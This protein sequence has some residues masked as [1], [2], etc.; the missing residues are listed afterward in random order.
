MLVSL[1]LLQGSVFFGAAKRARPN[2]KL[3][4]GNAKA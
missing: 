2:S 1:V 4:K 3:M